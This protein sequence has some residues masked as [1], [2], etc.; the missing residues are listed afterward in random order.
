M[1]FYDLFLILYDTE[2]GLVLWYMIVS[3]VI[4][5]FMVE[6]DRILGLIWPHMGNMFKYDRVCDR[7]WSYVF[8]Y[9]PI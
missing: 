5:Y 7:I 3:D 1:V 6:Y 9:G 8:E 4:W 2:P